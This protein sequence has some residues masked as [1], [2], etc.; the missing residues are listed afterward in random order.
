MAKEKPIDDR[1]SPPVLDN[2]KEDDA[3][4]ESLCDEHYAAIA[5]RVGQTVKGNPKNS[6][7]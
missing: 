2:P 1:A 4:T 7:V 3:G 5:Q 6:I